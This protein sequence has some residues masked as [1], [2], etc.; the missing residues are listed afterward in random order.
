MLHM[1]RTQH[2]LMLHMTRTRHSLMLHMTRRRSLVLGPHWVCSLELISL[3]L[4]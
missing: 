3:I 2:S 4:R 1:T